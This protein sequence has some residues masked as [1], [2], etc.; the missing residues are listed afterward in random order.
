MSDFSHELLSS[1]AAAFS[2]VLERGDEVVG[3]TLDPIVMPPMMKHVGW[4]HV[5][6]SFLYWGVPTEAG[7][8]EGGI[9]SIRDSRGQDHLIRLEKSPDALL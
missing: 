9:A 3:L 2:A 1:L 4:S 6:N 7:A 5:E 8:V